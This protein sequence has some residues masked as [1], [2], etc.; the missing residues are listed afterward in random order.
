M[1]ERVKDKVQLMREKKRGEELVKIKSLFIKEEGE[2]KFSLLL[3]ETIA[4]SK[5]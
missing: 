2:G 1:G 5:F 4:M 3:A